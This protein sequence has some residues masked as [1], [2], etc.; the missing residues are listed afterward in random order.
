M[1]RTRRHEPKVQF[2]VGTPTGRISKAFIYHISMAMSSNKTQ[3]KDR[4]FVKKQY[5]TDT[6]LWFVP[7]CESE[8]NRLN[9]PLVLS[10][11]TV[12]NRNH[13]MFYE[14]SDKKGD[15]QHISK[16]HVLNQQSTKKY[17]DVVGEY[18]HMQVPLTWSDIKNIELEVNP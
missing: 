2:W 3:S 10:S 6:L 7:M 16:E 8:Y 4:K 15:R 13:K 9:F 12:W 18:Y 14:N 1:R 17:I 5:L 11:N